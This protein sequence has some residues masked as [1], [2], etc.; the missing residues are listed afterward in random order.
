MGLYRRPDSD[1]WW[2]SFTAK[3]KAYRKSTETD[4]KELAKRIFK[5]I[6]GKIAEGKW[7]PETKEELEEYTFR[8]LAEK[9]LSWIDGRQKSAHWKGY[10]IK[11]LLL[12]FEGMLL[13]QFNTEILEQ[14]QTK[15]IR[16]GNKP[17]TVNRF[18]A[19]ISHMFTKAVDWKMM[20][21]D[22]AQ[23]INV[24]MLPENNKRLRYLSKDECRALINVCDSHLKPIVVMALNTGMRRGEI[25]TLQ[26]NKHI[27]LQHGFILLDDTKN[28]ERREIPIN[29]TLREVLTSLP[30]GIHI[31]YVF[32]EP[33][34]GKPYKDMK[35]SFATA[36]RKAGIRDFHFH[37][38]RHTFASQ[39]VMS[40]VDLTT[41]KDLLGHKTLTM[42]LRYA[43]LTQSHKA[44]A[45]DILDGTLTN[46]FHDIFTLADKRISQTTASH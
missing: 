5:S 20:F 40:G 14:F 39:L 37:D 21:K 34:T 13:N 38:L 43:H 18:L 42:T 8:E 9:Y 22:V 44:N 15:K 3:G 7:F 17:A 46:S 27:D 1:V 41:V 2:M 31:P 28:G 11:E 36:C 19:V 25:L 10:L 16:K 6:D 23:S 12:N 30:R 32:Y 35:K 29:G 24:K 26:W 45:L 4:D 33:H